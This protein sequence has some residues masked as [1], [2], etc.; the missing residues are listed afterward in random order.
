[1][2]SCGMRRGARRP[3]SL[4]VMPPCRHARTCSGHL[5]PPPPPG[6]RMDTRNKSGYDGEEAF[7]YDEGACPELAEGG[8]AG[9]GPS[10]DTRPLTRSLLRM[11]EGAG[12]PPTRALL[13]M[14]EGAGCP[15]TRALLRMR[16]SAGRPPPA[17]NS[18]LIL[19]SRPEGG[20]SKDCPEPVEG[21][22]P[23]PVERG[24][25]AWRHGSAPAAPGVHF[26]LIPSSG[27]SRVSR[28][29]AVLRYTPAG[30]G[31]TQDEG[32]TCPELVEGGAPA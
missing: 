17:S 9:A 2:R 31:A 22:C 29:G 24:V 13:R 7:G 23:E 10:F 16:V 12:C 5:P 26:P 20:V 15:P 11:R 28:D 6:G 1:M 8:G 4:P 3:G 21:A 19:S 14:R 25:R 32:R 30:A 27:A 18:P